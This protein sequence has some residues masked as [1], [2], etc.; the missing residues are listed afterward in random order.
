MF[1][2]KRVLF[3]AIGDIVVAC[4]L[5]EWQLDLGILADYW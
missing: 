2:L 4:A 3:V 5:F 1:T